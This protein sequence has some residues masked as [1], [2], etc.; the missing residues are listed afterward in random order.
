V[1]IFYYWKNFEEDLAT[2][3]IGWLKS[4]RKKLG[5]LQLREPDHIW[6]FKTPA[7]MKGRLQVIARLVWLKDCPKGVRPPDAGSCIYYDAKAPTSVRFVGTESV[8]AIDHASSIIRKRFPSAF[9]ANFQGDGGLQ[10]L[11]IDMIRE[12]EICVRPYAAVPLVS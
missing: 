3:Q 12:L 5:E 6:A 1:D 2:G 9:I 7:R 10:K 8:A 4:Q 11:E